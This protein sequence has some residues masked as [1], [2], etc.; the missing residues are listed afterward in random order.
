MQ[1]A[2]LTLLMTVHNGMP[3]LKEALRSLLDQD[4]PDFTILVLDNGSRDGSG[5]F[6]EELALARSESMPR[7]L[8]RRLPEN[9]GRSRVLAMGL[10]MVESEIT[11]ILDADD[12]AAPGRLAAQRRFFESHAG[13]DLLGSDI[14][15]IDEHGARAGRESYPV[16]HEQLRDALPLGNP[17]AHSAC[18]F[19]T[20]AAKAA[21]GYDPAFPYAQDL[22]LWVAMLKMGC[23]A[24]SLPEPLAFIRRHAGQATRDLA[25]LRVRAKDN[26]RLAVAMLDIPDLAPAPAQAARVRSALALWRLNRKR[27][28]LQSLAAAFAAA[29]LLFFRNPVL[30]KR[31]A[32]EWRKKTA[33][34]RLYRD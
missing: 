29:P 14:V 9:V 8:L 12:L 21:G 13:I 22:A 26:H 10:D 33:S 3:Y 19:R 15:Y 24:A 17:F 28:A 1:K 16:S 20:E 27:A 5:D 34:R 6:L 2:T 7:L 23:R 25:L 30:W 32:L 18:A 11:A 31:L 4:D